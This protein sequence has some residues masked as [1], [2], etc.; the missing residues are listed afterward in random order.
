MIT[1]QK[2]E[3]RAFAHQRQEFEAAG[4]R[5][6][7]ASTMQRLDLLIDARLEMIQL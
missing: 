6:V 2:K 4:T 5:L 7:V 3:V 1:I